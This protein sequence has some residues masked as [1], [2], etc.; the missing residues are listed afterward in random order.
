LFSYTPRPG[1]VLY[2]GYGDAGTG[3]PD[4]TQRFNF[5][6]IHRTSDYFFLKYSYLF[7]M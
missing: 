2:L 5:V 7:R 3:L 1:T 6:P 4:A